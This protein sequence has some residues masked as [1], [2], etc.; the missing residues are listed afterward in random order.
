M[1][2]EV[3][4]PPEPLTANSTLV[5]LDAT[6]RPLVPGQLVRPGEPPLAPR[7]LA[8]ERF[9]ARVPSQVRPQVRVL[10][11]DAG[12]SGVRAREDLLL[13]GYGTTASLSPAP[14][15]CRFGKYGREGI[16]HT[17]AGVPL[18]ELGGWCPR[19]IVVLLDGTRIVVV[20]VDGWL[21]RGVWLLVV[22]FVVGRGVG[23]WLVVLEG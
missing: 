2:G 17:E 9:L 12:A 21:F 7:P 22:G 11:V 23:V 5:G 20:A 8:N 1:L 13:F 3:V 4:R 15:R 10:G 19:G 16:H 14:L 6:V 18:L